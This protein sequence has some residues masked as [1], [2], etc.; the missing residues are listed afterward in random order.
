[1]IIVTNQMNK[2]NKSNH[3]PHNTMHGHTA[4]TIPYIDGR[5]I[6][7]ALNT[8][9]FSKQ[10]YTKFIENNNHINSIKNTINNKNSKIFQTLKK[11]RN[12]EKSEN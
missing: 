9:M 8:F 4:G 11:S 3:Y 5:K 1:M 6:V 12:S 7:L 10:M 2:Q